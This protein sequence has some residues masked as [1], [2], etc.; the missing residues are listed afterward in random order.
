M[1]QGGKVVENGD[2]QLPAGKYYVGDLCYVLH[3]EWDEVCDLTIKENECINGV[4]TLKNGTQ[5]ALYGTAYGDG[6]YYD[7]GGREYGVDSGTL[8]CVLVSKIDTKNKD[9]DL[10]DGNIIRFRN[11][12][13]KH[14]L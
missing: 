1:A 5:F 11:G 13:H 6:G 10:S 8:G 4:F 2:V 7:T 14:R 12:S 3:D 9:N